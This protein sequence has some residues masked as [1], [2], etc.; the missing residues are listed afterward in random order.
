M[1]EQGGVGGGVLQEV[2]GAGVGVHGV[3]VTVNGPVQNVLLVEELVIAGGVARHVQLVGG[4]NPGGDVEQGD[5]G[6]LL[7]FVDLDGIVGGLLIFGGDGNLGGVNQGVQL[8]VPQNGGVVGGGGVMPVVN[9]TH[10]QGVGAGEADIPV[11]RRGHAVRGGGPQQGG[12]VVGEQVE[13]HLHANFGPVALN[14]GDGVQQVCGVV[15]RLQ[16]VASVPA[17]L[18]QQLLGQ[19]GVVGVLRQAVSPPVAFRNQG[20]LGSDYGV[21]PQAFHDSVDVD[22]VPQSLTD[23]DILKGIGVGSAAYA[24]AGVGCG[25]AGTAGCGGRSGLTAGSTGAQ[26]Q[27]HTGGENQCKYLFHH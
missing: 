12:Q 25:F 27:E 11:N 17:G 2:D 24:G 7:V 6:N 4:D 16:G 19:F 20:G 3:V 23:A 22:G 10:G 9:L 13:L 1:P 21:V 26:C 8:V 15:N 14:G 5:H 18:I